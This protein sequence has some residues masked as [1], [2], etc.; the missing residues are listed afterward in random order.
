MKANP[1][2][3]LDNYMT[4]LQRQQEMRPEEASETVMAAWASGGA[5]RL[6]EQLQMRL[7]LETLRNHDVKYNLGLAEERSRVVEQTKRSDDFRSK[8]LAAQERIAEQEKENAA[9]REGQD[10]LLLQYED[11]GKQYHKKVQETMDFEDKLAATQAKVAISDDRAAASEEKLMASLERTTAMEQSVQQTVHSVKNELKSELQFMET[12]LKEREQVLKERE[13]TLLAEAEIFRNRLQDLEHICDSKDALVHRLEGQVEFARTSLEQ[14]VA[15]NTRLEEKQTAAENALVSEKE[16]KTALEL[17]V[18]K[19]E[20]AVQRG[21]QLYVDACSELENANHGNPFALH[22]GSDSSQLQVNQKSEAIMLQNLLQQKEHT[23]SQAIAEKLALGKKLDF[24][25]VQYNSLLHK[26]EDVIA[27]QQQQHEQMEGERERLM[28]EREADKQ[29][30][31][32]REHSLQMQEVQMQHLQQQV[33]V[34]G[35]SPFRPEQLAMPHSV[36]ATARISPQRQRPNT[37]PS[38]QPYPTTVPVHTLGQSD[39]V[40]AQWGTSRSNVR[41]PGFVP[42]QQQQQQLQM[43]RSQWPDVN[44][45]V[46]ALAGS[47]RTLPQHSETTPA[48]QAEP[49]RTPTDASTRTVFTPSPDILLLRQDLHRMQEQLKQHLPRATVN[50]AEQTAPREASGSPSV[51]PLAMKMQAAIAELQRLSSP[52]RARPALVAV[53][54]KEDIVSNHQ[55]VHYDPPENNQKHSMTLWGGILRGRLHNN[56]G[57][58]STLYQNATLNLLIDVDSAT[59]SLIS[60]PSLMLPTKHTY[61]N[62][63]GM[64]ECFS[65]VAKLTYNHDAGFAADYGVMMQDVHVDENVSDNTGESICLVTA[66]WS[67]CSTKGAGSWRVF[68]T[69]YYVKRQK[70][71]D[72]Q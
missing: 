70:T 34:L 28:H 10:Y 47:Q 39:I 15:T 18:K 71:G 27:G 38:S 20:E 22:I 51:N 5:E 68:E 59:N 55:S 54:A 69:I 57:S 33:Q 32:D 56:L 7:Q 17:E 64:V 31:L 45:S 12:R 43:G 8:F 26:F 1:M 37:P 29:T 9:L 41:T 19:L 24:F 63:N 44:Y 40:Q 42:D 25:E 2:P 50:K 14:A 62:V 67:A 16:A 60:D 72:C 30:L 52:E 36:T 61:Y 6:R 35:R 23:L 11:L 48:W 13:A 53:D 66:S 4:E 65:E 49:P 3:W 46:T 58:L 21:A